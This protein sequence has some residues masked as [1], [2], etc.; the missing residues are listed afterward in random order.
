VKIAGKVVETKLFGKG[1]AKGKEWM[2]ARQW[3]MD[4]KQELLNPSVKTSAPEL[5]PLEWG[6][7][8]LEDAKSRWSAK[9]FEEKKASIRR[10]LEYAKDIAFPSFTANFARVYLQ[11]QND[12]RSG[13]ASNR[14]R[15]V[16][17]NAWT[18]GQAFLSEVG[19][20]DKT[21]PF[22]ALKRYPEKRKPRRIPS[23]ADFWRMFDM[24]KGQDRI[25]L[26][27]VLHLA[28]RKGEVFRLRWDDVDM[29]GN[30]VRLVTEKTGGKGQ[31]ESWLPMTRELRNALET[32]KRE[33]PYK[34]KWVFTQL[35]DTPSPNHR[36][37]EAFISRQHFLKRLCARA[38]V[39]KFDWHAIRHP[40]A[41]I[42]Y[43][44]GYKVSFI[45][46]VLRHEHPVQTET[47]LRSHGIDMEELR[48]GL[49][50][51]DGRGP[52][53]FDTAKTENPGGISSEVPMYTQGVH[54]SIN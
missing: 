51:F 8:Y 44:S 19:F 34:T 47:Y 28:A 38:G 49:E 29:D 9:T 24:A 21:N 40:S 33:R 32:W 6:I 17:M 41:V 27:A 11:L 25:M 16:L 37:G 53:V 12:T 54:S 30:K 14:D 35:D 48:A 26:L 1:L 36:P 46:R 3:E 13:Y 15:K 22:A 23:E 42:L 31:S 7:C 20:P 5:T 39:E 52:A 4:R 50:I 18:W 45:Q 10:F 43:R 2:A